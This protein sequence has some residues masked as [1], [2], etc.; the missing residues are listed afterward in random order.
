MTVHAESIEVPQEVVEIS[1]ELGAQYNICPELIQAICWRESRFTA[2]ATGGDCIGIMQINPRFFKDRMDRLSVTD[3]YDAE[4]NMT[5]ATDYLA[6]LFEEHEDAAAVLM[7]YHGED[8]VEE[9]L[10]KGKISSYS[11]EILEI[12]DR[13]E[14]EKED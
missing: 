6:D 2:D 12:S 3:L 8:D 13:L 7:I 4:Q 14:N 11:R 10:R 1:E 9:K 5:V